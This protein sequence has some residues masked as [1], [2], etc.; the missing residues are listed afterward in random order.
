LEFCCGQQSSAGQ[1]RF[2]RPGNKIQ[3][4]SISCLDELRAVKRTTFPV[5]FFQVFSVTISHP[6]TRCIDETHKLLARGKTLIEFP[7]GKRRR[8]HAS[9]VARISDLAISRFSDAIKVSDFSTLPASRVST[10]DDYPP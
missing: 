1:S 10:R 3:R 5:N 8:H 6:N 4:P 9:I 2:A 7:F